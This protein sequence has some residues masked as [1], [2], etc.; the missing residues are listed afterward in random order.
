MGQMIV[1]A[2][3]MLVGVFAGTA[4]STTKKDRE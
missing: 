1:G 4:I 3:I 2:L